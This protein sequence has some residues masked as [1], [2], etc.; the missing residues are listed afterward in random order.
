MLE[1]KESTSTEQQDGM[2]DLIPAELLVHLFSFFNKN[3]KKT[4]RGVSHSFK[5][6][7]ETFF[8]HKTIPLTYY[9]HRDGYV[10]S[11]ILL[12]GHRMVFS[13]VLE[14]T[15][16]LSSS[17]LVFFNC[18][19]NQSKEVLLI[20][21]YKKNGKLGHLHALP[22]GDLVALL[23]QANQH[24]PPYILVLDGA[25]GKEKNRILLTNKPC[26]EYPNVKELHVLSSN[27]CIAVCNSEDCYLIDIEN[28]LTQQIN[29]AHAQKLTK[30]KYSL[31]GD[32]P[33]QALNIYNLP[34]GN[35]LSISQKLPHDTLGSGGHLTISLTEGSKKL[36]SNEEDFIEV[37]YKR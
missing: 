14:T 7:I 37:L 36:F 22:N 25:T 35:K 24:A 17:G 9:A 28:S 33:P 32:R 6:V 27:Q 2:M 3:E 8:T 19:E 26:K 23:D 30:N 5:N 29:P 4:A 12:P 15:A 34:D 21:E 1:K 20:K 11:F 31:F 13:I 18:E 16:S 10:S